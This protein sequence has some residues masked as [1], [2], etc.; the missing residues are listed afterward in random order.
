L[1]IIP[2]KQIAS[3]RQQKLVK[4][5]ASAGW[6]R[7]VTFSSGLKVRPFFVNISGVFSHPSDR[8]RSMHTP[9]V[10]GING[11]GT[12]TSLAIVDAAL[13]VLARVEAGPTNAT[14]IG[15]EAVKRS[16]ADGL[17]NLLTDISLSQIAAIGAGI[18]GVDRPSDHERML[19]VFAD[20]CPDLPVTLDNDAMP[21]LVAG[22]GQRFGIVTICGTG[23]ISLGINAAGERA[24]SGGWGNNPD[25]GSGYSIARD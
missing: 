3:E 24:R 23:M 14:Y 5:C 16:L 13:N 1:S 9:L 15:I 7:R 12:H 8:V 19:G 6:L 2:Y 21:A 22:V 11:G 17:R 25:H 4:N 10:I 20:L 18:A